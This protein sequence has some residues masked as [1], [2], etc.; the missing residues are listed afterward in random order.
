MKKFIV[1]I[2]TFLLSVCSFFNFA[3]AQSE[4]QNLINTILSKD[5][6]FW[7][8]YNK[9]DIESMEQFF[10]ADVEFYHDRGGLTMGLESL[11]TGVRKNLCSNE[12]F[13]LRRK[14]VEGSI[15]VFPLQNGTFPYGVILSGEHVFYVLEKDKGERLDGLAKFTHV[16]LLRDNAWKMS[17]VLSYDHGPP[18][19]VNQRKVIKLKADILDQFSGQYIGPQSGV[20]NVQRENDLLSLVIGDQKYLLYPQSNNS[21]FVKDRDLTFEFSK[22]EKGNVSRMVVRENGNIVEE[23]VVK[24]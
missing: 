15:K 8:A 12:N 24:K 2:V 19:Y 9:C 4:N 23:A 14:A 10:T 13:K 3:L 1:S 11:M 21:F 6:L 5:S 20:C 17:R 7:I 16:W 18:R 22:N